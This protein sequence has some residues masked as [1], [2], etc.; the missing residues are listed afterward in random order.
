MP[1]EFDDISDDAKS[2]IESLLLRE[3]QK[4]MSAKE[5]LKH[6]WLSKSNLVDDHKFK[7]LST[8]KHKQFLARQRWQ[9]CGQ[10]IR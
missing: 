8:E 6:S 9:K 4:R 3:K 5:C 10:A 2:F 7:V 1:Q